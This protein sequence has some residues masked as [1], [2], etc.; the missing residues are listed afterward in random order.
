MFFCNAAAFSTSG[1]MF[2]YYVATCLLCKVE[3]VVLFFTLQIW[4]NT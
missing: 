1:N 2:K 3:L 4:K